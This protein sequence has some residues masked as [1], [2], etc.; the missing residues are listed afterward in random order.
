MSS[1]A[2]K[3]LHTLPLSGQ[4]LTQSVFSNFMVVNTTEMIQQIELTLITDF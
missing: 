1:T 3:P 2:G 4:T